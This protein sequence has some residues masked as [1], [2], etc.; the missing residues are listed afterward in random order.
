MS[1]TVELTLGDMEE[2]RRL[3]EATYERFKDVPGFYGNTL[4]KH[5]LGKLGEIAVEKWLRSEEFSIDSAFRDIDR[6]GEA[7]IL[8]GASGVEVKTWRPETWDEMGRCVHPNQMD[9]I[10][11]KSTAIVWAVVDEQPNSASVTLEGW[12]PPAE[13]ADTAIR[14]TGPEHRKVTNHQVEIADLRPMG[15][16]RDALR[17][18]AR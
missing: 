3:A 4:A 1:V 2:A 14:R 17:D 16:L 11:A 9:S 18:Q 7:D 10:A 13:I 12:S 8:V 6:G 15:E 5:L